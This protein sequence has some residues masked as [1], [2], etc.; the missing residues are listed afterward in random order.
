MVVQ[1]RAELPVCADTPIEE[2]QELLVQGVRTFAD[3]VREER[4]PSDAE[5]DPFRSAAARAGRLLRVDGLVRASAAAEAVLRDWLLRQAKEPGAA[6][7]CLEALAK[8]AEFR[9]TALLASTT[10]YL[11]RTQ[12]GVHRSKHDLLEDILAGRLPL[13]EEPSALLAELGLSPD[14]TFDVAVAVVVD[15]GPHPADD[16]IH[17]V[18]AEFERHLQV[19]D[20][21]PLVVVRHDEV[22]VVGPSAADLPDRVEEALR[23]GGIVVAAG[24]GTP[25]HGLDEVRRGYEDAQRAL[26]IARLRPQTGVVSLRDVRLLD[27]MIS[28]ADAT[29]RR[30]VD[31][32]IAGLLDEDMRSGGVL[33]DTLFAYVEANLSVTRAAARLYVHPNTI[34]YRLRQI[35]EI[36]GRSTRKFLELLELV[37]AISVL[38]QAREAG[39]GT[40][41]D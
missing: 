36:T 25:C 11:A 18:A 32:R 22:I 2:A 33:V 38:R 12:Q 15:P 5:L 23:A 6:D 7:A 41:A 28:R 14:A 27:Y 26:R 1:L 17:T 40:R 37:C 20:R 39:N 29:A 4:Q 24:L 16:A 3:I 21:Q 13:A 10:A 30:M 34:H 9:D 19:A 35:S 31:P 8:L